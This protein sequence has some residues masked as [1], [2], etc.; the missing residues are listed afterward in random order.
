MIKG[1]FKEEYHAQTTEYQPILLSSA[2]V[3]AAKDSPQKPT[4]RLVSGSSTVIRN[5]WKNLAGTTLVH[6]VRAA[7]F[8]KCCLKTGSYDGERRN[9]FF[10][11]LRVP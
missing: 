6:A 8:K 7:A 11:R 9:H 2:A 10:Q 1:L 3:S 5:S 4:L